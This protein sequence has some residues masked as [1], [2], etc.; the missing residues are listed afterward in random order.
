MLWQAVRRE[1]EADE[2]SDEEPEGPNL[3]SS[4]L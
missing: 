3:E 4:G 2:G 1:I